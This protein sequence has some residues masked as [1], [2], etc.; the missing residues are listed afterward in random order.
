[1][2]R[3]ITIVL[4]LGLQ[5]AAFAQIT[6]S[7]YT[8]YGMGTNLGGL[9]GIGT[10]VRY[11]RISANAAIGG[12]YFTGYEHVKLIGDHPNLGFDVGIKC[13]VIKGLFAGV[14]YG[15]VD[16]HHRSTGEFKVRRVEDVM[17][18]SFTIGYKQNIYKGL[19]GMGYLGF[20]DSKNIN[21]PIILG[22]Q[23]SMPRFGFI[24]GWDFLEKEK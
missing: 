19:Y 9:V 17:A 14:N 16:K 1:M 12:S 5:V 10:E 20:T 22:K 18:F 23:M 21:K 8:G 11:K 24:L 15:L 2:K 4:L 13:Y 7:V 3:I 6:P